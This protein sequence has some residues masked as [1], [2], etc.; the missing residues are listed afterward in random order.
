MSTSNSKSKGSL[1]KCYGYLSNKGKKKKNGCGPSKSV[2]FS[3]EEK[4]EAAGLLLENPTAT[5]APNVSSPAI[6][7][8]SVQ[9]E[10]ENQLPGAGDIQSA[11]TLVEPVD[12]DG[13]GTPVHM[14]K[15]DLA[16]LMGEFLQWDHG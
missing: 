7:S 9:D 8:D 2:V 13:I 15:K 11:A 10:A 14:G 1:A 3:V 16:A 4:I 6:N 5:E 12:R